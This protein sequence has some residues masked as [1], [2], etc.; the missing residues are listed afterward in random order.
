[1][2]RCSRSGAGASSR[3]FWYDVAAS[4]R[5]SRARRFPSAA[6]AGLDV[7]S[8]LD[9]PFDVETQ[10]RT[11]QARVDPPQ[12]RR[13]SSYLHTDQSGPRRLRRLE[14]HR[15]RYRRS[16]CRTSGL[17]LSSPPNGP[18]RRAAARAATLVPPL[19]ITSSPGPRRPT[20]VAP[21]RRAGCSEGTV[22]GARHRPRAKRAQRL[23]TLR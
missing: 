19:R 18:A 2:A 16:R 14:Q 1:M 6:T 15:K 12:P 5:S 13:S 17:D 7:P 11:R 21:A 4:S 9:Q 8:V 10:A 22:P 3:T 23:P 20:V